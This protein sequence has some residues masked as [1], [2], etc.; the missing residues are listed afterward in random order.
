VAGAFALA[1]LSG[2]LLVL[3][4]PKFDVGA[5]AWVGLIP[6]LVAVE[7]KRPGAAFVLGVV[8]GLVFFPGIFSWIFNVP[9]Y[10]ILDHAVLGVYLGSYFGLFALALALV[11]RRA[12]L[13][14]V[15]AAPPLWVMTE[16]LR[17]HAWLL[18]FPWLLLGYSQYRHPSVIQVTAWT[19]IYG[20]GFLIVLTNALGADLLRSW[21]RPG[22]RRL[23]L[24]AAAVA[25]LLVVGYGYGRWVLSQPLP[26]ERVRVAVVQGNAPP[27]ALTRPELIERY[28]TLT[29]TAAGA[30][31]AL[32]VWPETALPGDIKH[33]REL[34]RSV[35][36]L[37]AETGRFLLVGASEYAK[38][39]NAQ[40]RTPELYKTWYNSLFLVS[41]QGRI[42]GEYRKISLVPF[43]EYV[44]LK[45]YV[46]WPQA[47]ASSFG[48]ALPGE[49]YT[50][51]D[52]GG[53]RFGAVICWEIMFPDLFR[54]FVRRGATF[55]VSATNESWFGASA[56][57][58]QLLAMTVIR[59]AENRV[60]IARAAN[61]GVSAFV[62]PYGR[63][64][65]RV[66]DGTGRD[67]FV[68]GVLTSDIAVSRT[69]TFYARHGDVF[70]LLQI[71]VVVAMLAW[72]WY[73]PGARPGTCG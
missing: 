58:Y 37:A 28:A 73:R 20:V 56:A 68:Q 35:D 11:R 52:A 42:D 61:T 40:L 48:N 25:V 62:D 53:P 64:T 16:Y 10:N 13:S 32:I 30:G 1:C 2:V 26:D 54:Q 60:A 51:F 55:M 71:A 4:F 31:P 24:S 44:P 36:A 34:R 57:P 43:G 27:Q 19:G 66:R 38:F 69:P 50:V 46:R 5:L 47:I 49:T 59:A 21:R 29:R 22:D 23:V 41:P 18:T 7:G 8:T 6:M 3:A 67:L 63:I 33:D 14:L 12:G 9:G 65:D 70:A 72:C 17:A 39:S 45:G 15:V